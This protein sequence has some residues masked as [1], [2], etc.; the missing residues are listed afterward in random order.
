[1]ISLNYDQVWKALSSRSRDHLH[2]TFLPR[3]GTSGNVTAE[4][5]YDM[6][7][8]TEWEKFSPLNGITVTSCPRCRR[9]RR[10]DQRDQ[11]TRACSTRRTQG[12]T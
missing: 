12:P 3:V 2:G 8:E 5:L 10:R 11:A 1:M 4:I 9:T 6:K 7:N